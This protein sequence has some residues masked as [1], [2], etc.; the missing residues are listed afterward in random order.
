VNIRSCL[1]YHPGNPIFNRAYS[2][3]ILVVKRSYRSPRRQQQ[4]QRTRQTILTAARRLFVS[5]G[6]GTTT[7]EAIAV[8]AGVS[9]QT[10]YATFGNKR[11]M[12]VALLD[13]MAADAD[14]PRLERELAAAAGDTPRQLRELLAFTGRFY[15][16]GG[17]LIDLARTVSGVEPDLA[18]MWTTGEDRRYRAHAAL[19]DQWVHA[20]RLPAGSAARE[21]HDLL[22]ALTGPDVF[23][24]LVVERHWSQK[25]RV[26]T[27]ARLLEAELFPTTSGRLPTDQRDD[28]AE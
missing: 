5:H 9:V 21:A 27:I 18:A 22:W 10:V 20:G 28:R 13:H 16:S 8:S 19:I 25:R 17:D 2:I 14:L 6:Y 11:Q 15:A 1:T 3:Q 12:L 24:L 23:R 4:A 26:E 7:I